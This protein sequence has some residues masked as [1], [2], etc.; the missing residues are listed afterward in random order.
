MLIMYL[1]FIRC[2]LSEVTHRVMI[3]YNLRCLKVIEY[4]QGICHSQRE[5]IPMTS[6]RDH[7][8]RISSY[9]ENS[10]K[11]VFRSITNE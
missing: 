11:S 6:C 7:Y 4:Q 8:S 9:S 2:C 10:M 5:S 1:D 3:G